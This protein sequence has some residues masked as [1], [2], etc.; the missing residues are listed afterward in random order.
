MRV[1]TSVTLEEDTIQAVDELASSGSNR[2]RIIETAVVE[3]IERWRRD[4]REARD[5]EILNRHAEKFAREMEDVLTY[6]VPL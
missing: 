6:Q 2:S 5:L 1:K 4:R 3:Y